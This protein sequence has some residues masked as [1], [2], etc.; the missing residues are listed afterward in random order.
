MPLYFHLYFLTAAVLFSHMMLSILTKTLF[1]RSLQKSMVQLILLSI[2]K[3]NHF[4]A[5]S[6]GII[7]SQLNAV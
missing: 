7:I 5:G 4:P 6:I 2:K 1:W 3:K